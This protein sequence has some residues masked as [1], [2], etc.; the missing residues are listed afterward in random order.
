MLMALAQ[1]L[2][3]ITG[4]V[5]TFDAH[6]TSFCVARV[7]QG[8]SSAISWTYGLSVANSLART[9]LG[10]CFG[11]TE[12]AAFVMAMGIIG[13]C[14]GP[15]YVLHLIR[16]TLNMTVKYNHV[17]SCDDRLGTWLFDQFYDS[18]SLPYAMVTAIAGLNAILAGA[19]AWR[20]RAAAD[21][22]AMSSSHGSRTSAPESIAV[23][24]LKKSSAAATSESSLLGHSSTAA[25]LDREW[26]RPLDARGRWAPIVFLLKDSQ[27]RHLALLLLTSSVPRSLLVFLLPVFTDE[28]LHTSA[29]QNAT[30]YG[31]SKNLTTD[32]M[33]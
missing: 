26:Q 9:T 28:S 17:M 10:G 14:C 27:F 16:L 23:D 3:A 32:K 19:M 5:L 20:D 12:A 4:L 30:I 25:H 33:I 6:Y 7:F 1:F 22:E 31:K 18:I 21:F 11:K 2:T 24:S 29:E 8:L 15:W 13:E